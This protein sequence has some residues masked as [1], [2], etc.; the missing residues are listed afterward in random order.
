[1]IRRSKIKG[2]WE[3]KKCS[4]YN[5]I[6]IQHNK[7]SLLKDEKSKWLSNEHTNKVVW[8]IHKKI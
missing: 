7:E 5:P 8:E 4:V 3:N 2:F 1:M 6:Y